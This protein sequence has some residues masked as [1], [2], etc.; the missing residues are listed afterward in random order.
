MT[1]SGMVVG[2]TLRLTTVDYQD[3]GRIHLG[4][5]DVKCLLFSYMHL[6]RLSK[7]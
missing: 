4:Q 2:N 7:L 5:A 1:G 3:N 6:I